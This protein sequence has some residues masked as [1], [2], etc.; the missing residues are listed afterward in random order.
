MSSAIYLI[1]MPT[2][3]FLMLTTLGA[4][5]SR[6]TVSIVGILGIAASFMCAMFLFAQ[7]LIA[8]ANRHSFFTM[9][10]DLG[11]GIAPIR[12]SLLVDPLSITMCLVVTFISSWIALYSSEYMENEEGVRRFF[13]LINLFVAFMLILVLADNLWLLFI[14]WEGVGICSYLLIGFYYGE[15][16]AET[17]AMKAFITT[18]IGDVFLLFGMLASAW[19]FYSLD[20]HEIVEAA[21]KTYPHGSLV[22]TVIALCLL[23]G[24]VGKSA[25]LPLQIWLPDAMWGPTPVSALIHAATMV[26]AGVYLVARMSPLFALSEE[27]KLLVLLV[28]SGTLILAGLSA[29]MQTDLKRVLAYSTMSQIGYMFLALGVEAPKAAI[30]HLVT[31]AFFKALLFL[32]A[33]VIGHAVHSYDFSKMGGL[34]KSMPGVFWLFLIGCFSLVG[35]PLISSG[36]FS[37]E[38]ILSEAWRFPQ[39]GTFAYF[40]GVFGAVLTG[41]YTTRM[42]MLTFFGEMS[43]KVIHHAGWRIF[44][45]LIVLAIGSIGIGWLEL[46][47]LMGHVTAISDY[48]SLSLKDLHGGQQTEELWILLV[49]STAVIFSIL[50]ALWFYG[51]QEAKKTLLPAAI[52]DFVKEGLGFDV[53]YQVIFVKPFVALSQMLR[54]D[55]VDS[56]ASMLSRSFTYLLSIIRAMHTGNLSHY[57]SFFVLAALTLASVL[58]FQ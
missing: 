6:R 49:P 28:G 55:F 20:M 9:L 46:P 19:A 57:I 32:S 38:R 4:K 11:L 16:G 58:V 35:L 14:G 25:Q 41:L 39:F 21:Q 26:T 23:G 56:I 43:H 22:V 13:A 37:K 10:P 30:F 42:V 15:K 44:V 31:H 52:R 33:G 54:H 47:S 2:L 40:V 50:L 51:G 24:A 34:R 27:A 48:L 12:F 45:P 3:A 53:I 7:S 36:F 1:V 18:T 5:M 8:G 17:A 29:L